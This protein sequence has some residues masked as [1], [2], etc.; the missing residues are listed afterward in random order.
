MIPRKIHCVWVGNAP[1]PDLVLQCMESW[2]KFLPGYELVEWGNREFQAIKNIYA[3]QAFANRKWAFV[4]DYIRLYALYHHGGIYLDGDLEITH[5]LDEFLHLSFFSSYEN[6]RGTSHPVNTA[7]MA[8]EPGNTLIKALLDEY[9]KAKFQTDIGLDQTPNTLRVT[10]YF[11]T[12]FN[13]QPPYNDAS[14]T[15]LNDNSI[16]FPASHFC[17]PVPGLPNYAVHHFHGSWKDGFT[18]KRKLKLPRGLSLVR[19]RKTSSGVSN[20]LPLAANE[21]LLFRIRI[22]KRKILALIQYNESTS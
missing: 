15:K 2:R 14:T 7:I 9:E 18:R 16:I 19:F 4:S 20:I 5:S 12:H 6:Y 11:S 22:S 8:A 10:R 21:R 3:E 13:I 17:T 1:K